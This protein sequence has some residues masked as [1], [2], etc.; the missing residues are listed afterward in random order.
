MFIQNL[1]NYLAFALMVLALPLRVY[2][3][4][5]CEIK[6]FDCG[7][8]NTV[9]AKYNDESIA[10]DAGNT[11]SKKFVQFVEGQDEG[12][13]GGRTYAF[14]AKGDNIFRRAGKVIDI[15]HVK[16]WDVDGGLENLKS[17][18]WG[19][20]RG[21]SAD[22]RPGEG[23]GQL[24]TVTISH[25]HADH[26]SLFEELELNTAAHV[27]LGGDWQGKKNKVKVNELKT[28]GKILHYTEKEWRF[29]ED[30]APKI[31]VL[32]AN[33]SKKLG[34]KKRDAN[35]D[36]MIVKLTHG[37]HSMLFT[38]DAEEA[39]WRYIKAKRPD[40]LKASIL[41]LSHH[42]AIR[43]G[44]TFPKEKTKNGVSKP[45][46][47]DLV[48]PTVCLIS[49][50]FRYNHPNINVINICKEYYQTNHL[51]TEP[52]FISYCVGSTIHTYY[53]NFPIFT[54]MDS[55]SITVNLKNLKI[56]T[57]RGLVMSANIPFFTSRAGAGEVNLEHEPEANPVNEEAIRELYN[58]KASTPIEKYEYE[59]DEI[60]AT[61]LFA[62]KNYY[63]KLGK[64]FFPQKFVVEESSESESEY[65][66][67]ECESGSLSDS[68]EV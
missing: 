31:S 19:F 13:D 43:N 64:L 8:G 4:D 62:K 3:M 46:L 61:Y 17:N 30:G 65:D 48:S 14:E 53:T 18:Y 29:T 26:Y 67:S 49:A 40:T 32:A 20:I 21:P 22:G 28:A 2:G 54:T 38:G 51:R 12:S 5:E 27:V 34:L 24:K 9:V 41:I 33:A 23:D 68:S 57:S 56:T 15:E 10:F 59:E 37:E 36:S 52:H 7:Q 44:C 16:D 60:G 45:G 42:G 11:R 47:L 25:P 66:S 50:G 6:V 55:G 58:I 63:Y 39:T 35:V 1:R